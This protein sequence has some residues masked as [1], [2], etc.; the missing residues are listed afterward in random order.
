[1][2]APTPS[3]VTDAQVEVAAKKIA[4][5]VPFGDG[6]WRDGHGENFP[7]EYSETECTLI[8]AIAKTALVAALDGMVV[9]GWQLRT[10]DEWSEDDGDVLW[11]YVKDG[12]IQEAPW[13][14]TPLVIGVTVESHTTTRLIT[15]LDQDHDPEPVIHRI[16]VGGW[17]GYHT[18]WQPLPATPPAAQGK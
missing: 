16:N 10:I 7:A 17:P 11:W 5:M 2:T 4:R 9:Q 8:R 15:Q 13:V 12:V 6:G 18:H 1:M 14:G 3:P